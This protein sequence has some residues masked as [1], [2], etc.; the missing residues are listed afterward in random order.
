LKGIVTRLTPTRF[1][2]WYYKH[3]VGKKDRGDGHF[4]VFPT[5]FK[6]IVAPRALRR[7]CERQRLRI[8]FFETYDGAKAYQISSG[9]LRRRIV[10]APYYL[11]AT[12]LRLLTLGRWRAEESDLLLVAIK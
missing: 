4:D 8:A 10:A 9:S 3:V 11:I 12:L 2:R 1:H 6:P 7:W 5:P